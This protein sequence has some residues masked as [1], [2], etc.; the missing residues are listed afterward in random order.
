MTYSIGRTQDTKCHDGISRIQ[1]VNHLF[2]TRVLVFQL[3]ILVPMK[4]GFN[5]FLDG[6]T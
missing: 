1:K 6:L 4:R 5:G 2:G 3:G